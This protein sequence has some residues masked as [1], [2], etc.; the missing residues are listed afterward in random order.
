MRTTSKLSALGVL[1]ERFQERIGPLL[2]FFSRLFFLR[3]RENADLFALLIGLGLLAPLRV[4]RGRAR[5]L[6]L[7]A[8]YALAGWMLVYLSTPYE[9][10]WHLGSSAARVTYQIVPTLG[11]WLA[12]VLAQDPWVG[13]RLRRRA[14]GMPRRELTST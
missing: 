6:T 4:L 7:L 14:P 2:A 10:E 12:L 11:L 9:L 3:P 8:G 1:V 13:R 5:P